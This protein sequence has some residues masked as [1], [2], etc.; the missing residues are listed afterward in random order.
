MTQVAGSTV[1][2]D[3]VAIV[4]SAEK[5]TAAGVIAAHTIEHIYT[6]GFVVLLPH[7]AVSLGLSPVM[8]GAIDGSRQVSSGLI[9]VISG[10]L[11]DMYQHRRGQMLAVAM[12]II[13]LGYFAV[14]LVDNIYVLVVVAV[15]VGNAGSGLW[16]PPALGLLAE[17]FPKRKGFVISLHRSTGSLGD[18]I[19]PIIIGAL[20][21]V[22]VWQDVL[23]AGLIMILPLFLAIAMFL[24]R[25]GTSTPSQ[26]G[27]WTRLGGQFKV[28]GRSFSGAGMVAVMLVSAI[29]GMGDRA[30]VLY[31]PFYMREN[32]GMGD[33]AVG[34]HVGLLAAMGIFLGPMI[35]SISDRAGRKQLI[36]G[37]MAV[38]MVLPVT[39]VITGATQAFTASVAVFGLFFY[40]VNSLTQAMAIDLTQ[41]QRLQGTAIGL[42]WG[43]NA[44]F[45]AISTILAGALAQFW[46]FSAAFYYAAALFAIGFLVSL[47][48][49]SLKPQSV[50]K[51]TVSS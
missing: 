31:L 20:L 22:L 5:A 51:T 14:S 50:G 17:R 39:M 41:G 37:I 47:M 28:T 38:S 36:V 8:T 33:L 45:G 16:H 44:A 11:S 23:R 6:R 29:R 3:G 25:T 10:I 27:F 12:L 18:F 40:S 19:G 15:M 34:F 4:T 42:M 46:G 1:D 32:L 24:R 13:G 9:S 21:A 26:G 2:S 48:L 35:G 30:L 7:I 49:P 43:S